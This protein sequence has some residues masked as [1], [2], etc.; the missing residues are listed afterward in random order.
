M[1]L[2][3]FAL[4]LALPLLISSAS[5]PAPTADPNLCQ[6]LKPKATTSYFA[7]GNGPYSVKLTPKDKY[8]NVLLEAK[9]GNYFQG[10]RTY[11]L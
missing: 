5:V 9:E 3:M 1:Y 2:P 4:A 11:D 6:N 10:N 7:R 8:I